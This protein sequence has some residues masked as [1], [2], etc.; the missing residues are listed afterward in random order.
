VGTSSLGVDNTLGDTLAVKVRNLVNQVEVLEQDGAEF[1]GSQRVL[2][3][4]DGVAY[5]VGVYFCWSRKG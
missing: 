2:V 1:A 3:V 5:G 4:I